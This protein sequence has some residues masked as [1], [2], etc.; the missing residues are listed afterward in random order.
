[1]LKSQLCFQVCRVYQRCR[2]EQVAAGWAGL[3][4]SRQG[5]HSGNVLTCSL[6]PEPLPLAG[7]FSPGG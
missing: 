2:T 3:A 4:G 1:M 7:R 5:H 6:S